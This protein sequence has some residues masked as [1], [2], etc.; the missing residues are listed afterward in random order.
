MKSPQLL[1]LNFFDDYT[2]LLV[3]TKLSDEGQREP[4]PDYVTP[5]LKKVI[6]GKFE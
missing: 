6:E 3:E 4:N 5:S 1:Q 2:H